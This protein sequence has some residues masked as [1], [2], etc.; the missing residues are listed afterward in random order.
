MRRET[1]RPLRAL[2]EDGLRRVLQ[3]SPPR[4][5][6]ALPDLRAGDPGAEDPLERY[7][8][9]ELREL[10]YGDPGKPLIAVD[11]NVLVYAH[12]RE[13]RMGDAAHSLMV[14]LSEGDRAWAIPWP[15]CY[16]FLSVV[17]NRRIWKDEAD[18]P[19]ACVGPATGLDRITIEPPHRRD[20]R[21]HGRSRRFAGHPR[22][23]GG[24][25]HDARIAA[26][27]VAH[28]VEAL[29]TRDRELLGVSGAPDSRS[30]RGGALMLVRPAGR[31]GEFRL[32]WRTPAG[33][34][35]VG[36]VRSGVRSAGREARH[37]S[38]WPGIVR[39]AAAATR[40][41]EKP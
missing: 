31:P 20:R 5:R 15:C 17:T 22:V 16:E 8:W 24:V 40:R 19:A 9:P 30:V 18:P 21:L 33:S 27:C 34:R 37:Q 38:R 36:P 6:Y 12:R 11:S 1:G 41:P 7:S 4:P 28:G 25:V 2:V 23:V 29:L 32:R 14:E 10:I 35:T 3:P 39:R 13:A 26:I